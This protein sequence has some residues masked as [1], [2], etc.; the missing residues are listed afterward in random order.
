MKKLILLLLVLTFFVGG[1]SLRTFAAVDVPSKDFPLSSPAGSV[2]GQWN[3]DT[4]E[5]TIT[6]TGKIDIYRWVSLKSSLKLESEALSGIIFA[7]A[8]KFPD[9]THSGGH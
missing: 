5:L 9:R 4:Q 6:G 2:T 8:V 3:K 7:K 1:G